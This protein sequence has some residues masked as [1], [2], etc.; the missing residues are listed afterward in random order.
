MGALAAS[1][2]GGSAAWDA[3]AAAVSS[4][5]ASMA[6]RS[7][8]AAF[9]VFRLVDFILALLSACGS[10]SVLPVRRGFVYAEKALEEV[11]RAQ[12]APL[13]RTGI[14]PNGEA[15]RKRISDENVARMWTE[16]LL[17]SR[18]RIA[19]LVRGS[20]MRMTG[21]VRASSTGLTAMWRESGCGNKT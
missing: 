11:G 17:Q 3:I 9:A 19:R 20:L 14:A 21:C 1:A 13:R 15:A 16:F 4:P 10:P 18:R 7:T 2:G 8:F 12:S 6:A 5:A